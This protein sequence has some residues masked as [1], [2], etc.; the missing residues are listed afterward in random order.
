M[1]KALH[2]DEHWKTESRNRSTYFAIVQKDCVRMY[3]EVK[4][5]RVAKRL[6]EIRESHD[7]MHEEEKI[8][9][10]YGLA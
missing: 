9:I 5:V 2:P 4:G 3:G 10:T 1:R 6:W 7:P 8:T